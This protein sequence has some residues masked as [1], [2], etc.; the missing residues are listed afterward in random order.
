VGR[1]SIRYSTG[2]GIAR[3]QSAQ[4]IVHG[5]QINLSNTGWA[6]YFDPGLGRL[7]QSSDLTNV[8]GAARTSDF[9][10]N[11]GTITRR[12]FLSDYR[13]DRTDVTHVACEFQSFVSSYTGVETQPSQ[14]NWCTLD[15]G[16][17]VPDLVIGTTGVSL[18]RCK[19]R[20]GADAIW[21]QG[22]SAPQ[23][24]IETYARVKMASG[25]DHNDTC[26]CSGGA[27]L[28]QIT[29]CNLSVDPEGGVLP[30]GG[31]PDAVIMS[32]D[33]NSGTT[34]RLE[35]VDCLLD[36]T[37]SNETVRFYD[38]A[39]TSNITYLATGNLFVRSASAP[40]GRGVSNTTPTGQVTWSNNRWAD[41]LSLISLA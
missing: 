24:I 15:P 9:V 40:V 29:R 37:N 32:S 41:D 13:V 33:L 21:I 11:G 17:S 34:Y 22:G 12:R 25:T 27:G 5:S 31:G 14:F 30:G 1:P 23:T 26:Q 39:L 7:V 4:A 36:G 20:G 28:V 35:V 18:Y 16:A 2:S 6:A 8:S 19:I 10:G 38:G 3:P